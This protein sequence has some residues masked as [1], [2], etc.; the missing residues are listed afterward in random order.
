MT[1][2][3]GL[4]VLNIPGFWA[5]FDPLPEAL[6]R[7]SDDALIVNIMVVFFFLRSIDVSTTFFLPLCVAV[8]HAR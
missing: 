7:M 2:L 5:A 8:L 3:V 6:A 1:H 4:K